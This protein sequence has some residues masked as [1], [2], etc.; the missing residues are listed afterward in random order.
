[1]KRLNRIVAGLGLVVGVCVLGAA[2]LQPKAAPASA[3][4]TQAAGGMPSLVIQQV[5]TASAQTYAK[6]IGEAN[7]IIKD[8][9]GLENYIHV[10]LGESA[11]PESGMTF[12]VTRADSFAAI[13]ANES[14]FEKEPALLELRGRLSEIRTFGP[15][16]SYKAVRWEG[17]NPSPANINTRMVVSD[18]GQYLKALDGLRALL[19]AHDFK[20]VKM[21]VYR[22]SVGRTDFTH[23]ASLNCPSREKRAAV[24]D[25]LGSEAWARD[26]Q[27]SVATY[28]TVVSNG[29][30]R[31][32]TPAAK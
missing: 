7:A 1:M 16:V 14:K 15:N 6:W 3:P 4:P 10:F 21:N 28:R 32:I 17:S 24:L 20:D 9:F 31:E 30:Y 25:A 29:T 27:T 18:E 22:V 23:F 19:D 2:A 5:N 8:K 12:A 11:G 13:V 26:W